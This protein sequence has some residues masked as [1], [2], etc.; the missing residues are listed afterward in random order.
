MDM[1]QRV[2]PN[3]ESHQ[4]FD[5]FV[6]SYNTVMEKELQDI[7]VERK[8]YH[9]AMGNDSEFKDFCDEN[10]RNIKKV[11]ALLQVMYNL[12]KEAVQNLPK[13]LTS[14]ADQAEKTEFTK[15]SV[16]CL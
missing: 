2:S 4:A 9:S 15:C 10:D 3:E 16:M 1:F 11:E 7:K 6:Y 12:K 14:E 13:N 8:R 5:D